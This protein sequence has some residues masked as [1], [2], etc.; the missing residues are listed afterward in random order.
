M[1]ANI[2]KALEVCSGEQGRFRSSAKAAL[3]ATAAKEGRPGALPRSRNTLK[4]DSLAQNRTDVDRH[5]DLWNVSNTCTTR[6]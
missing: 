6:A 1:L 3:A 2:G 4:V 5:V